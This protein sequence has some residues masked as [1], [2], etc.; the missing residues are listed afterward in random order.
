MH[1]DCYSVDS[2]Q[3]PFSDASMSSSKEGP[4]RASSGAGLSL[5]ENLM[6]NRSTIILT[7]LGSK[8]RVFSDISTPHGSQV[9]D[10]TSQLLNNY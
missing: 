6:A 10:F 3:D 4:A 7:S 2:Y 8:V 5:A 9:N 1:T